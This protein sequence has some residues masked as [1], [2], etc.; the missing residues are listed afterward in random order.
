M[1]LSITVCSTWEFRRI[2]TSRNTA[3]KLADNDLGSTGSWY[4]PITFRYGKGILSS[5]SIPHDHKDAYKVSIFSVFV[6]SPP[7][8]RNNTTAFILLYFPSASVS[9]VLPLS[10]ILDG[11]MS[12][13][14]CW[15]GIYVCGLQY[16]SV[17][18]LYPYCLCYLCY[19]FLWYCDWKWNW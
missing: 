13:P 19:F 10:A 18:P 7:P 14:Q 8:V 2:A 17:P 11:N 9:T 3:A 15:P 12:E 6:A 1:S 16:S 5:Y 4:S